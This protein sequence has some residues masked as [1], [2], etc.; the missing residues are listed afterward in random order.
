MRLCYSE[1]CE[2]KRSSIMA[3]D[4]MKVGA[5]R[6]ICLTAWGSTTTSGRKLKPSSVNY[7]RQPPTYKICCFLG[8]VEQRLV[9]QLLV[10]YVAQ[11]IPKLNISKHLRENNLVVDGFQWRAKRKLGMR[12][13]CSAV[14]SKTKAHW[15]R[16]STRAWQYGDDHF[17]L[18]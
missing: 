5:V 9:C 7:S 14:S 4:I 18:N 17:D 8:A 16:S 2:S 13:T 6:G 1:R 11:N 10:K 15:C 3:L 12:P